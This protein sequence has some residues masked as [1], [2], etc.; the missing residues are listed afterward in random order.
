MINTYIFEGHWKFLNEI[1]P[2]NSKRVLLTNGDS[3]VIGSIAIQDEA[4]HWLF[5]RSDLA[6]YKPIAWMDLPSAIS[7][8]EKY[9][10]NTT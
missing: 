7:V 5:D 6:E 9:E 8:Q 10:K 1:K 2:T 4:I 3:I